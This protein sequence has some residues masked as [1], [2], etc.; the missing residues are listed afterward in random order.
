[1]TL[2]ARHVGPEIEGY[3]LTLIDRDGDVR[4]SYEQVEVP[5]AQRAIKALCLIPLAPEEVDWL[6]ERFTAI[7]DGRAL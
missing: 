2:E 1:M 7:R 6:I 5:G 3:R 4:L